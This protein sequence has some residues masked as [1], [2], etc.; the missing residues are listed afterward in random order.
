MLNYFV[1]RSI[2]YTFEQIEELESSDY[3]FIQY[4]VI[5]MNRVEPEPA[6][7]RTAAYL[8]HFTNR[9]KE[10]VRLVKPICMGE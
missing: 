5:I 9:V 8:Y 6:N 1:R 4:F 2:T 10:A 3:F 7:D